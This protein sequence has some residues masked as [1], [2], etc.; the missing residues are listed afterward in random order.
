MNKS[1]EYY[2]AEIKRIQ[3]KY[4]KSWLGPPMMGIIQYV[5]M[6]G[7]IKREEVVGNMDYDIDNYEK[8]S[9]ESH[10]TAVEFFAITRQMNETK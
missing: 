9:K 1:S 6:Q 3:D 10:E 2:K 5:H 4:P 8:Q 7:N